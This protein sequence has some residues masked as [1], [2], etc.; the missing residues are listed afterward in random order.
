MKLR[1]MAIVR[2]IAAHTSIIAFRMV[3]LIYSSGNNLF[4]EHLK[5]AFFASVLAFFFLVIFLFSVTDIRKVYALKSYRPP[6]P[7]KLLDRKGRLITTFFT[8]QRILVKKE[9]L[10]PQLLHAIIAM[11]DNNFYGHHGV[12]PQGILRAFLV[13]VSS[14]TVRQGGSTITQQLAKVILT[15]AE[16]SL[17]RK[18]KEALL[19]LFLDAIFKKDEILQLYFN[20]IYFGHGAY[21]VESASRFYFSKSVKDISI[22]EAAILSSLPAAPNYYSPV[23]N[24]RKSLQRT[25]GALL[26]MVERGF[27]SPARAV[28]EYRKLLEYFNNL[29]I[30]P[31][32]NVYGQRKDE[33][34]YYSETIRTFLE[35]EI[36]KEKLYSGGLT[37]Y[38]TLDLDH[39]NAAQK[40]L[41]PALIKQ[42]RI[43][44]QY[45]FKKYLSLSK[46]YA[47]LLDIIGLAYDLP[48]IKGIRPYNSYAIGMHYF[49][50]MVDTLELVNLGIGGESTFDIFQN[51]IRNENPYLNRFLSVEGAFVEIDHKNGEI[52]AMIG[53]SPFSSQ[54]QINRALSMK[55]QPGSTFKPLIYAA[56]LNL[57][58]VTAASVFADTPV[59]FL[60]TQGGSWMPENYSGGY[61]GFISLRDAL[62]RSINMVS[63]SVAREAS[64][65][66]AWPVLEKILGVKKGNIPYNLSV[67]LGTYEVSPIQM[68][69]A[70]SLFPRGGSFIEPVL[71][72]KIENN[73]GKVIHDFEKNKKAKQILN[74]GTATVITSML[75]DVVNRGTGNAIRKYGV[76]GFMAGKTGT[77]NNF[78]D[79]WFVGFNDRYTSAVWLGYDRP[80]LSLG[81]GQSGGSIAAPIWGMYQNRVSRYRRNEKPY[82]VRGNIK[83]ITICKTTGLLPGNACR[84][85]I[86]E[87]FIPGTEPK[88]SDENEE[89]LFSGVGDDI[90]IV[91]EQTM[92]PADDFFSG[93]EKY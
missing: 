77:T 82:L 12:S 47:P 53:G 29:N 64:L 22:G 62:A 13:N 61:S 6:T 8:D 48:E 88:H 51:E 37:I 65:G 16:R 87:I 21:G 42:N 14:G 40:T 74:T 33:A 73:E 52:T 2:K 36:G 92:P 54:N 30:P 18:A 39:Q 35:K 80:S 56:A 59:I 55:R 27:I 32:S 45:S 24:P 41:W 57:R 31:S 90:N 79:A 71:I 72:K 75:E 46:A 17:M 9:D 63:I 19:A 84:E 93:D 28:Q 67:A 86:T 70:F 68:V 15:N 76:S 38:G 34:P 44:R 1:Q 89:S 20:Q 25:T 5:A 49:D 69:T 60:D 7:S 23:R 10:P 83:K 81:Q 66:K 43:S 4:T 3:R 91:P 50:E 78:S 11:E 26:K 58:K 85:T